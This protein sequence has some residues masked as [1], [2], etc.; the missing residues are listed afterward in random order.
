MNTIVEQIQQEARIHLRA[1][2]SPFTNQQ[3]AATLR[4]KECAALLDELINDTR[5][6]ACLARGDIT[7][8]SV[9]WDRVNDKH[10][11]FKRD[12]MR[13]VRWTGDEQ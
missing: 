4:D 9:E 5:V 3:A 2:I 7:Q 12:Q 6:L 1:L 13:S 8:L 10:K 11:D